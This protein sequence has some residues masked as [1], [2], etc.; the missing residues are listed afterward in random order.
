MNMSGHPFCVCWPL[1]AYHEL[2]FGVDWAV[3]IVIPVPITSAITPLRLLALED[4]GVVVDIRC[5]RDLL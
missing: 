5:S 4:F 2:G 1:R 3:P